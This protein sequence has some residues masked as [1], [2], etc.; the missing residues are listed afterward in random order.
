MSDNSYPVSFGQ[1]RMWFAQQFDPDGC[2]YTLG[3]L[4]RVRGPLDAAALE[5]ALAEVTRRHV[6]LRSRFVDVDGEPRWIVDDT[7][8]GALRTH[9]LSGAAAPRRDQLV[10]ARL[11][12]FYATPFD[13][14][15]GPVFRADLLRVDEADHVLAF[16]MHH[17]AGDWVSFAVLLHDLSESY[18]AVATGGTAALPPVAVAATD[19][20]GADQAA[21]GGQASD[22]RVA[23]WT[24]HVAGAPHLL[25]LPTRHERRDGVPSTG[26]V[27]HFTVP[28][29]LTAK[30]ADLAAASG[31][32]THMATLAAFGVLLSRLSGQEDLLVGLPIAGRT[33]PGTGDVVGFFVN[34]LP[35]RADLRGEPTFDDVLKRIRNASLSA[36]LHQ[37]VPFDAIVE[38]VAPPRLAGVNPLVQNMFQLLER[39]DGP[40]LRLHGASVEDH[41]LPRHA[42]TFDLSLNLTL[43]PAGIDGMFLYRDSVLDEGTVEWC[44]AVY[45]A[46]LRAVTDDPA[47]PV[48][49]LPLLD[50]DRWDAV[51]ALGGTA[52]TT[53]APGTVVDLLL[54]R[55]RHE[56]AAVIALDGHTERTVAEVA[57][58][59]LAV[60]DTVRHKELR[61]GDVVAVP[62]PLSY[63]TVVGALGVLAAGA[64]VLPGGEDS[65]SDVDLVLREE[66]V[67]AVL[68]PA[69]PGAAPA[70]EAAGVAGVPALLVPDGDDLVVVSHA[71]LA[72]LLVSGTE[73]A[74]VDTR[75]TPE[76]WIAAPWQAI[77]SLWTGRLVL[78]AADGTCAVDPTLVETST[79][80]TVGAKVLRHSRTVPDDVG[81]CLYGPAECLGHALRWSGGDRF[82]AR[83]EPGVTVRVVDPAGRPVPA[84]VVGEL[85]FGSAHLASGYLGRSAA[86]ADRFVPDPLAA[87]PEVRVYRTG[88]RGRLTAG[89]LVHVLDHGPAGRAQAEDVHRDAVGYVAPLSGAESTVAEIMTALLPV[90]RVGR[91]GNFFELGGHSL[92]AVRLAA[93]LRSALGTDVTVRQVFENPTVAAL[94]TA[95]GCAGR[96]AELPALT[97]GHTRPVPASFAQRRLWFVHQL[98]PDSS[99]YTMNSVFR[100]RGRLD[101]PRLETAVRTLVARHESLRTR[102]VEQDGVLLQVV[103]PDWRGDVG[104][105][106]LRDGSGDAV[107]SWVSAAVNRTFDL[108]TGPLFAVDVARTGQ[109]ESLIALT[110]H[111]S[112]SDGWSLG[113]LYRDLAACYAGVALEALPVQYADF[114]AWQ[115]TVVNG[116]VLNRQLDFW[117]AE[118]DGA[119]QMLTLPGAPDREPSASEEHN[120]GGVVRFEVPEEVVAGLRALAAESRATLFMVSLAAFGTLLARLSGVPDLLVGVPVAARSRPEVDDVVGLFVNTL[121]IRVD[122]RDNPGF[123]ELVIRTRDR[124]LAAFAH[125]DLPFERLVEA[126]NPDRVLDVAPLTQVS[127]QLFEEEAPTLRLPGLDVAVHE[128]DFDNVVEDPLV[129]DM[130]ATGRGLRGA[131]YFNPDLCTASAVDGY[132]ASFVQLLSAVAADATTPVAVLPLADARCQ[133]EVLALGTG[134]PMPVPDHTILEILAEHVRTTPD[135]PAV[136]APGGRLSFAELDR[137]ADAVAGGLAACGVR[138]G[139]FVAL[140]VTRGVHLVAALLGVFRAGAAVLPLDPGQPV[141][142]LRDIVV[143]ADPA[144]LLTDAETGPPLESLPVAQADVHELVRANAA[145]P[146]VTPRPGDVAL[147]LYTSGSTGR[148]KGVLLEHGGLVNLLHSHRTTIFPQV[149]LLT[150]RARARVAL[151]ASIAFDASWDQLLWMVDGHELYV[152]DDEVRRDSEALLAEMRRERLD[153]LDVPQSQVQQLVDLGMLDSAG[154]RPALLLMGGEVLRPSLW[155]RLRE[156]PGIEAYNLYGPTEATIDALSACVRDSVRPVVGRAVGGTVVRVLDGD[157]CPVPVGV[158]GELFLG[159]PHVGRGYVGCAGLSAERFVP[160]PFSGVAGSRLYR[161]GDLGRFVVGGAVE[162]LGRVDRQLKVRGYRVEPA[163]IES[164]L[165]GCGVVVDAAVVV[166]DDRLT[167]YVVP[168]DGTGTLDPAELREH[169]ARRLPGYLVPSAY[170]TLPELP[171]LTSGK[172][173]ELALPAPDATA[174]TAEFVPPR[175]PVERVVADVMA[176]LLGVDRVGRFDD[177]F[178]VGGHSLSAVR[179]ATR[180]RAVLGAAV[181]VRLVFESPSVAGLAQAVLTAG[182][183]APVPP[184]VAGAPR[185]APASFAQQRLWFLQQLT[186]ESTSYNMNEVFRVTGPLDRAALTAAV[187]ALA[188]RHESLRTRFAEVGGTLRQLVDDDWT[189]RVQWVDLAGDEVVAGWLDQLVH[190]VFDLTT[191]PLFTV[192]IAR[193]GPDEHLIAFT[194]HHI[195]SDGWS[196]AVLLG[197]LSALYAGTDLPP[198]EVQYADFATWQREVVSGDLLDRQLGFWRREV[199]GAPQ[200]L[201]LPGGSPSGDEASFAGGVTRFRIPADVVAELR[202]VAHEHGATL[203][204]VVLST[205]AALLSRLSGEHDLLVGMPVAGRNTPET[206][207]VAGFFVN[208]LPVRVDL[209]ADPTVADLVDQVR[210]RVLAAFVHQ[211]LPFERIVEALNPDRSLGVN[212]LVQVTFQLFEDEPAAA[213]RLPGTVTAVHG[214]F[215][216]TARFDLSLDVYRDGAEFTGSLYFRREL[217]TDQAVHG[218]V[219]ALLVALRAAAT[220]TGTPV[221]LLSLADDAC[222]AEVLELGRGA[223]VAP[224]AECTILDAFAAQVRERPDAT[225]V[226]AQDATWSFAELDRTADAVTAGLAGLGV[227]PGDVVAIA[228]GRSAYL[229]AA[230]LG[231]LRA[232][233]AVVPLDPAQPVERLRTVVAQADPVLVLGD[234]SVVPHR[235]GR[236]EADVAALAAAHP[237]AAGTGAGPRGNDLAYVIFTSGSSGRPKGV[238]IEHGGLLNLLRGHRQSHYRHATVAAGHHPMRVALTASIAFDASWDQLLWMFDGNELHVVPDDVRRDSEALVAYLAEH[239]VDVLNTTPSFTEQLVEDGLLDDDHHRISF[240]VLGGEAVRPRLW[241]RLAAEPRLHAFNYYGPTEATIDALSACVRD[242]VRPVVGR[243]VGGTVVRVLDGDM[244]PVPVG[245]VGELFLGGPHVGR[246]YVG[247]AGLSA[248]RFVPDPFSGVAGSRLYRTGDL[249]RFVVGGAVEFLGRVDRQLKVRGYRVEPAEIESVLLGCGVVGDAVVVVADDRLVAYVVPRDGTGT[250]GESFV[251]SWRSV[252]EETH[253][254]VKAA[255]GPDAAF[256]GWND[257]FSGRTI[258]TAQMREWVDGTVD[259]ILTLEPRRLLE[260]GA[261]TGMLLRPLLERAPLD[262]YVATDLSASSQAV[263]ERTAAAVVPCNPAVDVVVARAE[264][265]DAPDIGPGGYDLV[266]LNSVAQYFPSLGHLTRTVG[267]AL[268]RVAPGGHVFLGDLRNA[269][270]IEAFFALKHHLLRAPK[271]TDATV[272]DRVLR[273][274]DGD[275]ELSVDPAYFAALANRLPAIT[276]VEVMPRRGESANEMTLFRY[277]VVL[278]VGCAAPAEDVS[279]RPGG[280]LTL[281]EVERGLAVEERPFGYRGVPNGRLDEALAVRDELGC[282][283]GGTPERRPGVDIEA[284]CRAA[285]RYGWHGRLSWAPGPGRENGVVDVSFVRHDHPTHFRFADPVPATDPARAAY[286]MFP[287]CLETSLRA[288]LHRHL[289]GTLPG[290]MVPS[291]VVFLPEL[292]RQTSGKIDTAALPPPRSARA[293]PRSRTAVLAEPAAGQG[294]REV[295]H[296]ITAVI[297]GVLNTAVRHDD[298]FFAVGGDSLTAGLA[299]RRLRAE[300]IQVSI[301]D[302]FERRTPV[303]LAELVTEAVGSKGTA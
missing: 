277:D 19:V 14:E 90:D 154:H 47:Q 221:S 42:V 43:S 126:V 276:A 212:P 132:V 186:P 229:A 272:A 58:H 46:I 195:I 266:V 27:L 76:M 296:R 69:E 241:E 181:S 145:R 291:L 254:T 285:E 214:V 73:R 66:D 118:I 65:S 89:G 141:D 101:L 64:V 147:V 270:L 7:W 44:A 91:F 258:P 121:P 52:T 205:F 150:G 184:L 273:D 239:R 284:L 97:A 265:L 283:P 37:D 144:V 98:A 94:A 202:A 298:D 124:V 198:L 127:F 8:R 78:P 289:A 209:R 4:F 201:T 45:L 204:M 219:R 38:A 20:L 200:V 257:S 203:F 87:D 54:A 32:T 172:V 6:S 29:D 182:D 160:D 210:D 117:L 223:E 82:A 86:T 162:F 234:G 189:G 218:Y 33:A 153:V 251:E 9:D 5:A 102:L 177:F 188:T 18:R 79:P 25:G 178:A 75:L 71:A 149:G 293:A 15:H 88:V 236:R 130:V 159:G 40:P 208:T 301:R 100:V 103:D 207:G 105:T 114:A 99:A 77:L 176:E 16:T 226:S 131:M 51:T 278:H 158:V 60:A 70:G 85:C 120:P 83:P 123:A 152:V 134:A 282:A 286:P 116:A 238:Q 39:P 197:D 249:G 23:F 192:D 2:A 3:Q 187:H 31:V 185:P 245:V 62:G 104:Q 302:L 211:D 151:T 299:V 12:E 180:L 67:A 113:V 164:V 111:H 110:M 274:L 252:F 36:Y 136:S 138:P 22:E 161:T 30:V 295:V 216:E 96:P 143:D 275:T 81:D 157:M 93:R 242:S 281:R 119:P 59:V 196:M 21:S 115:S 264:A 237:G 10:Q 80:A 13:L 171:R 263:L 41:P 167:A 34:T 287:P 56:P 225:A 68:A 106:D 243:A 297:A 232:G 140:A 244:C 112:V 227:V 170:V 279:W 269:Q 259:R 253:V 125:Q 165:L 137:A 303:R 235:L 139:R 26:R 224:T 95:A 292:P 17:I 231:I 230:V 222:V 168:Q 268:D 84:G 156:E 28:T 107:A 179:L 1:R 194:M 129:L 294:R 262:L 240:L 142:R 163:E 261:G 190:R 53:E 133:A 35:V 63:A 217:F 248:E 175:G 290:F 280:G 206:E 193:L 288:E 148:P 250:T 166:A 233:A 108:A 199:A 92:S 228:L 267:R 191:G 174:L 220:N 247:C 215:N 50:D 55:A 72:A 61:T 256:I 255:A 122:L 57:R 128:H 24:E 246:G 300:D 183:V 74:T 11:D 169:V 213:L 260:I 49:T 146:P 155:R 173:D 271:D 48:S 109:E 135:L